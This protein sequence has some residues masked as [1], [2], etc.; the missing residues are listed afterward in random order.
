LDIWTVIFDNCKLY[1][2]QMILILDN[3][4][5]YG[6]HMFLIFEVV[7]PQVAGEGVPPVAEN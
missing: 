2:S 7:V 6:P 5:P 3:F 4:K 1:G